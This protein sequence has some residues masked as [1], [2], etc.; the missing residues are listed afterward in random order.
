MSESEPTVHVSRGRGRPP[1]AEPRKP[2]TTWVEP[3]EYER[4]KRLAHGTDRSMSS[5]VSS[6]LKL[7]LK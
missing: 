1:L 6:M 7:R 4:L 5:L 2:L 3:R